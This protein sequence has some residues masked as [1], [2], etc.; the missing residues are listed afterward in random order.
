MAEKCISRKAPC[1]PE[2][3]L[4]G[5]DLVHGGGDGEEGHDGDGAGV[6]RVVVDVP[7]GQAKHLTQVGESVSQLGNLVDFFLTGSQFGQS[8]VMSK[9]FFLQKVRH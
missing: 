5:P 8:A 9:L 2:V 4:H 7:Q 3:F 6:H 1:A